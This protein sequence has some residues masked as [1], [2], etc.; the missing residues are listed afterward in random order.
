MSA[1][2]G[3]D[4]RTVTACRGVTLV[5]LL[6]V[7]A[8]AALIAGVALPGHGQHL[9]RARRGDAVAALTRLQA[10]QESHRTLH[11]TY[12]DDL[13][14]LQVPA[15]SAEGWYVLTVEV[16]GLDRYRA[17]ARPVEGG[18]QRRD[19]DCPALVLDVAAG[20]ATAGPD[21]RCWNR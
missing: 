17:Q 15:R 10:A 6:V 21:R 20:F 14:A 16:N 5:E 12:T 11:G 1:G 9:T 8:V 3:M 7:L 13:A 4:I 19:A 18:V 2:D